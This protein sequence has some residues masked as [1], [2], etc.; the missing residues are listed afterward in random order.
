MLNLDITLVYQIINFVIIIVIAKNY[1][2]R[3][4]LTNVEKRNEKLEYLQQEIKAKEEKLEELK[5]ICNLKLQEARNRF[6]EE[7]KTILDDL[8]KML[9]ERRSNEKRK[10]EH[11]YQEQLMLMEKESHDLLNE[12]NKKIPDFSELLIEKIL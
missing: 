7:R 3:P 9:E 2:L 4:I 5:K 11:Y 1:I 10:I 6:N 8:K 12:L